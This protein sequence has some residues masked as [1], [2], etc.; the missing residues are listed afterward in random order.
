MATISHDDVRHI[1]KLCR[2]S[3][4]EDKVEKFSR[5]LTSILTYIDRLQEV[6]TKGVKPLKSVTGLTN[7]MRED[8]VRED[9]TSPD[10]L[11]E[12]SPL[13]IVDH[14]IQTPSAHG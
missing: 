5:E 11:L 12:C 9:G 2:L 6:D 8:A 13:P 1:A 10:A 14:Q 3:L 7:A 4:E